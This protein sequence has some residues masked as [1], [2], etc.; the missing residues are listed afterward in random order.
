MEAQELQDPKKVSAI[1]VKN[2]DGIVNKIS[3]TK[4]LIIDK[5]PKDAN[6]FKDARTL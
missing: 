5:K 1:W 2:L 3:N 4:S 6:T